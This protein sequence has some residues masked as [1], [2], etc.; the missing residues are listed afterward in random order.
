MACVYCVHY[1]KKDSPQPL[2][3][4]HFSGADLSPSA[5]QEALPTDWA[6]A[7][8]SKHGYNG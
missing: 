4:F 3:R 2:S 1:N 5:P 8:C 6:L 7:S